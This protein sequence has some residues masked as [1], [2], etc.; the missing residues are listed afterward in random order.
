MLI[1][2]SKTNRTLKLL[3]QCICQHKI[4]PSTS[5]QVCKITD[6]AKGN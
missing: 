3:C 1:S 5:M 2:N 4:K 6:S